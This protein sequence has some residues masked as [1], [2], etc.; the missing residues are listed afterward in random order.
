MLSSVK[1]GQVL[2]NFHTPVFLSM[3]CGIPLPLWPV[4]C[5]FSPLPPPPPP[6]FPLCLLSEKP[7]PPP[8]LSS[9]VVSPHKT[10]LRG[11]ERGERYLPN[12]DVQI[13][14][15]PIQLCRQDRETPFEREDSKEEESSSFPKR[16]GAAG[17]LIIKGGSDWPS[18]LGLGRGK[19][20][21]RRKKNYFLAF[22]G[23]RR[24]RWADG[25]GPIYTRKWAGDREREK[26]QCRRLGP[27]IARNY[28]IPPVWRPP[29]NLSRKFWVGKKSWYIHDPRKKRRRR[30]K[31]SR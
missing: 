2:K 10:H 22:R 21:T 6:F 9:F 1:Q 29:E 26:G 31:R 16:V 4:N 13:N 12:D 19:V 20:V 27:F 11:G 14:D 24:S 7:T 17:S 25:N 8:P 18:F 15:C 23:E 5:L 30:L 3:L 28:L